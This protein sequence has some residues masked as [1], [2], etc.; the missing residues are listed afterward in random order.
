MVYRII[1]DI[2]IKD[3][4]EDRIHFDFLAQALTRV[5]LNSE[6]P[7]T[8]GIFGDWGAGKTSIMQMSKGLL[9][10]EAKT[11]WF[12]AWKYDK[13]YD[14]RVALIKIILNEMR[15]DQNISSKVQELSKKINWLG[16]AR[17]LVS[18]AIG[19]PSI[20]EANHIIKQDELIS[21]ISEF[22]DTFG[23]LVKEYAKDQKLV[24]F[25]DDLDRCLPEKVIDIL[26]AI[27]LFLDADG[28]ITL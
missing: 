22:D 15:K 4:K 1:S 24:I 9:K 20:I 16:I 6:T 8:L 7:V 25:I 21:V 2:E 23:Q 19:A 17:V 27:K 11:V 10:N 14:S 12:N 5:I 3:V 13:V 28:E 26:E 18:T